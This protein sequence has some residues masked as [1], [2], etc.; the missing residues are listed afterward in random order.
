M[1]HPLHARLIELLDDCTSALGAFKSEAGPQALRTAFSAQF[2][3]ELLQ[4]QLLLLSLQEELEE[5]GSAPALIR[6]VCKGAGPAVPPSYPGEWPP[7]T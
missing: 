1:R 5:E 4:V 2:L 7:L 3:H 6:Q